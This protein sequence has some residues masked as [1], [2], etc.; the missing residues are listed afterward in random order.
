MQLSGGLLL[1]GGGGDGAGVPCPFPRSLTMDSR[2]FPY[3]KKAPLTLR[4]TTF[5]Y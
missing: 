5:V 3:G 4:E 1:A 2:S